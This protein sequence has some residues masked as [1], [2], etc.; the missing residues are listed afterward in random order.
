M[1]F[2]GRQVPPGFSINRNVRP[3]LSPADGPIPQ[4]RKW[5]E[6]FY[7]GGDPRGINKSGS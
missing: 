4:F 7:L 2:V 6:Q 1:N 3:K 5:A